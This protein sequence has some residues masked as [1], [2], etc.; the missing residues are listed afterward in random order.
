M[1]EDL[2]L[3]FLKFSLRELLRSRVEDARLGVSLTTEFAIPLL[4]RTLE[5]RVLLFA[6]DDED[7]LFITD[8]LPV[9]LLL[10]VA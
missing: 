6:K 2:F 9:E 7:L 8:E 1:V 4:L 5:V 10:F 3:P